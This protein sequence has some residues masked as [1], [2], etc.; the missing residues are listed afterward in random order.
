M[1]NAPP[2]P[3]LPLSKGTV[4]PPV[5]R[6]VYAVFGAEL[7]DEVAKLVRASFPPDDTYELSSGDWLVASASAQSSKVYE[8]LVGDNSSQLTVIISR[9]DR[10]YGLHDAAVWDWIESQ[11]NGIA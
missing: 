5:P 4:A 3:P 7:P 2:P 6:H 10:V 9:V 1:T 11:K 8:Q